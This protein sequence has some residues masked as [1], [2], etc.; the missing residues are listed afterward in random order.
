[1]NTL[2]DGK[3]KI[4]TSGLFIAIASLLNSI[5]SVGYGFL[6]A[7]VLGPALLGAVKIINLIP[8]YM[9]YNQMGLL[10]TLAQKYAIDLGRGN[11]EECENTRNIV[12]SG[13]FVITLLSICV[14]WIFYF[15]GF[16]FKGTFD[17]GVYLLV[18]LM[19]IVDK[20]ENY[21]SKY[22]KGTGD[23][24]IV[25]KRLFIY[26]IIKPFVF[27]P[28]L[29]LFKVKGVL[30]AG[31]II[32]FMAIVYTLKELGFPGFRLVFKL[33]ETYEYIR[34]GFPIY[35]NLF[36][37]TIFWSLDITIVAIFLEPDYV[38]VYGFVLGIVAMS[39]ILADIFPGM[40]F[41]HM[42]VE[43]GKREK[44]SDY[45]YLKKY[46]GA[47]FLGYLILSTI[48]AVCS[49]FV[50]IVVTQ[51]FLYKFTPGLSIIY[52]LAF[53]YV[54]YS[55]KNY[56]FMFYTIT[57]R[58]S[59]FFMAQIIAV[60]LN[61]VLDILF[62]RL[63]YGIV[64]VALGSAISYVIFSLLMVTRGLKHIYGGYLYPLQL[65]IKFLIITVIV[66][67]VSQLLSGYIFLALARIPENILT[68]L[69]EALV[70]SSV[71]ALLIMILYCISFPSENVYKELKLIMAMLFESIYRFGYK[72]MSAFNNNNQAGG[73]H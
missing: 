9:S 16:T 71:V 63:G 20:A 31:L 18:T 24:Q 38:G 40:I 35:L 11:K 44:E 23:F 27:I 72:G 47:P 19:L 37:S 42:C 6:N 25:G 32:D 36:T 70:K 39:G 62:I 58:L 41:Q 68:S 17:L 8:Q 26:N 29:F 55:V 33:K 66:F 34:I 12:F 7:Y 13:L 57:D 5:L 14:L 43:K 45:V 56:I 59:K 3:K 4:I 52:L 2:S 22:I 21:L 15:L 30:V 69:I 50:F 53:A 65:F 61:I 73:I 54:I 64:G 67:A 28:L 48:V 49:V 60:I 1:M 10:Q 46:F 51:R